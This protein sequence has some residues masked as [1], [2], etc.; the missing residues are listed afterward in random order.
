MPRLAYSS[1]LAAAAAAAAVLP[2]SHAARK[3][4]EPADGTVFHCGGS[5]TDDFDP[6]FAY[7][8][9]VPSKGANPSSATAA[10]AGFMTYLGLDSLNSTAPGAVN[11]WFTSLNS[12]LNSYGS[13]V[14]LVPQ[15]GL[16]LPHDVDGQNRMCNGT[17]DNAMDAFVNGMAALAP[18]PGFVRIGYE[19]NGPWNSIHSQVYVCIFRRVVSKLR[20]NPTTAKT[21]ASVWDRT[22][23]EVNK[24]DD[25]W[26]GDDGVVDW[27][28]VNI[29]SDHSA[30]GDTSCVK[31]FMDEAV[32]KG[33]PV[34]L[35]EVTPRGK[36]TSD[37]STTKDWFE[38]Y[39]DLLD[40]YPRIKFVSYI[41]R[42]WNFNPSYKGW[43]D[44][45]IQTAGASS[46]GVAEEYVEHVRNA[47]R[48]LNAAPMQT[49][50]NELGLA[51]SEE[52]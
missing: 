31:P 29:Y 9:A 44:S 46:S 41:N 15:I 6:Y 33:Y 8:S 36:N 47:S 27:M 38:P 13:D 19:M 28:G 24:A 1:L 43:G 2:L 52:E 45:R 18:R 12:T 40:A 30:P 22:C 23:D 5:G 34:L 7:L 51:P 25:W 3:R 20:A 50:L 14:F 35:G 37:A 48:Y 26:P 4:L 16:A 21:V 11:Q 17:F 32:S 42:G 49:I 39:F 10:P